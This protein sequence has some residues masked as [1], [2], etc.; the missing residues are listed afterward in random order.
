[1]KDNFIKDQYYRLLELCLSKMT[2]KASILAIVFFGFSIENFMFN[3]RYFQSFH[4]VTLIAVLF[5]TFLFKRI[6]VSKKEVLFITFFTLYGIALYFL[7]H[8]NIDKQFY[9]QMMGLVLGLASYAFFRY[10]H[11]K[12][13]VQS[14]T[15]LVYGSSLPALFLGVYQF[16]NDVRISNTPRIYSFFSEPSHYGWYLTLFIFPFIL[17]D[18]KLLL[19]HKE[20]ITWYKI[21]YFILFFLNFVECQ[22][23]VAVLSM[24]LLLVLVALTLSWRIRLTFISLLF[25]LF[26]L[27]LRP[28]RMLKEG[29]NFQT[30]YVGHLFSLLKNPEVILTEETFF[31]RIIPTINASQSLTSAMGIMGSGIGSDEHAAERWMDPQMI[32]QIKRSKAG[33]SLFAAFYSKIIFYFGIWGLFCYLVISFWGLKHLS[34]FSA[35]PLLTFLGLGL[36]TLGNFSLPY[37]PFW[38]ALFFQENLE[39]KNKQKAQYAEDRP[40]KTGKKILQ[41]N[42]FYYPSIGGVETVIKQYSEWLNHTYN[43]TVLCAH[44]KFSMRTTIEFINGVKVIRCAS[45]GTFFSMPISPIL[46]MQLIKLS[47]SFKVI[48]LH[49]PF[50]L[51]SLLSLLPW[52]RKLI[53]TWHSDI[54]KQR[55]LKLFILPFQ[56]LLLKRARAITTTS[57]RLKV[58]SRQ[59]Y[60]MGEKV[61]VLPLTLN[62]KNYLNQSNV[63]IQ[64]LPEKY[65]LYIGRLAYYKGISTLIDAMEILENSSPIPLVIIGDGPLKSYVSSRAKNNPNIIFINRFLKDE[66]MQSALKNCDF[67]VFPSVYNSEAFGII[68]L[69]AM[70]YAK[71]VINTYLQTG[72]PWVSINNLT[73][74]TVPPYDPFALA[75][76]IIKI[77][78]SDEL[79][80]QMGEAAKN[81]VLNMFSD[82]QS[83]K[84]L[85]QIYSRILNERT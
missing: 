73:G 11:G 75:E 33:G 49:E 8:N 59:L 48:H 21:S 52:K 25:L 31:A 85:L 54:V 45:F 79:R 18:L 17:N 78:S 71:P 69:E 41:V 13:K 9:R 81:R 63:K 23:G 35:P 60:P 65:F 84:H 62:P 43:V 72:V 37:L 3:P 30:S 57:P 40:K 16:L 15:S 51:A 61:D 24:I 46:L 58:H 36:I 19:T 20:K 34:F 14:L 26:F 70:I 22:S 66:E 42:K 2:F 64:E 29:I 1:M 56:I 6:V 80:V 47:L 10:I 28:H 67:L 39:L 83:E 44:S 7:N 12:V 27:S 32:N 68:Q 50:P 74:L 82:E 76:A 5:C 53:V 55:V 77:S 38:L 4:L